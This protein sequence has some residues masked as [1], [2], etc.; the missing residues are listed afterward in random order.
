MY[1]CSS[2]SSNTRCARESTIPS[3]NPSFQ[4]HKH[5]KNVGRQRTCTVCVPC[6]LLFHSVQ[7]TWHWSP[8]RL[9][10]LGRA[11]RGLSGTSSRCFTYPSPCRAPDGCGRHTT[12]RCECIPCSTEEGWMYQAG[13]ARRRSL[14]AGMTLALACRGAAL[15]TNSASTLVRARVVHAATPTTTAVRRLSR[16][17]AFGVA[18]PG[19]RRIGGSSLTH[20]A[21]GSSRCHTMRRA[22][23]ARV[24]MCSG[25]AVEVS[26]EG[27]ELEASIKTKGDTIRELKAGG[28][29]KDDLK[30]H[31]EVRPCGP[32]PLA[33]VE[34]LHMTHVFARLLYVLHVTH[35][36]VRQRAACVSLPRCRIA[37]AG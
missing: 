15:V 7:P 12:R 23:G 28:A 37:G 6:F 5:H 30:P 36:R 14:V 8:G 18:V 33:C 22:G 10:G 9:V 31:I 19:A 25:T 2:V 21:D 13:R 35:S 3:P 24:S 16:R 26:A 27:L 32:K 34:V 29:S 1:R 11:S 20:C 4:P 17:T